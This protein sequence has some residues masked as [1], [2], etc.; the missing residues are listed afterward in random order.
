MTATGS[1][2]TTVD[3]QA[4]NGVIH[5]IDRVMFPIPEESSLQYLASKPNFTQ[6]TYNAIRANIATE[7]QG[8]ITSHCI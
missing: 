4:T 2:I 1:K 3:L 6:L 8:I 5:L 7:L